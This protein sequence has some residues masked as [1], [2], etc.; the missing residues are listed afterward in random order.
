MCQ[1]GYTVDF[2]IPHALISQ[3]RLATIMKVFQL[4]PLHFIVF[5]V[6]K[7]LMRHGALGVP[8]GFLPKYENIKIISGR[9]INRPGNPQETNFVDLEGA[10]SHLGYGLFPEEPPDP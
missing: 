9:D 8:M 5:V 3:R 1:I 4:S 6:S 2:L 7:S 10:H